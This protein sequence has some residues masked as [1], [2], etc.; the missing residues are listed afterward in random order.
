MLIQNK[1]PWPLGWQNTVKHEQNKSDL[2]GY[3][4]N[5][6]TNGLHSF[7][8]NYPHPVPEGENKATK[9]NLVS[10]A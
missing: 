2:T 3:R 1:S 8:Y 5:E 4:T 10:T 6:R 9:T 7:Q